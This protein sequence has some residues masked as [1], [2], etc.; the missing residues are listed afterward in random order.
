MLKLKE[1][2]VMIQYYNKGQ[3]TNFKAFLVIL[4]RDLIILW[5]YSTLA[6]Q[7][8]YFF[9]AFFQPIFAVLLFFF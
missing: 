2:V 9:K 4:A 3:E 7:Q 5:K 6:E 8:E 1:K